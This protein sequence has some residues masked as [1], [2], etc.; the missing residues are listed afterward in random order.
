MA[1][2]IQAS[3]SG[4]ADRQTLKQPLLKQDAEI[5]TMVPPTRPSQ[6]RPDRQKSVKK[7]LLNKTRGRSR[8][9]TREEGRIRATWVYISTCTAVM[10]TAS[11]GFWM[12]Y[13]SPVQ[14]QIVDSLNLTVSEFS[15]FGSLI[16]V[17]AMLGSVISGKIGDWLGR[18][19]AMLVACL[20]IIV[21]SSLIAFAQSRVPLYIG[22]F[23]TG[24]GGGIVSFVVPV[25]IAEI[26]PRHLRGTLGSMQQ[27]AV[28]VGI[29]LAYLGG[30]FLNWRY[31][32]AAGTLP[33]FLCFIGL[34]VI[35]ESPRWLASREK[36]EELEAALQKLR[37][38][39][40]DISP[41]VREM[42]QMVEASKLEP[43]AK[44]TDLFSKRLTRPLLAGV[45]LQFLQQF[46]GINGVMLYASA[47]F[48]SA[49][50]SNA[51]AA[52]LALAILQV[53]MTLAAAGLMDKAGRR[54]LLM[55]SG[56]GMALSCFLVG[57]SFYLRNVLSDNYSSGMDIFIDIL[58]LASLLVYIAAF[59]LGLGP[60]PWV[61]IAE[62]FPAKVKGV[63]GSLA[64]LV[65][66]SSAWMVTL[67]FNI[68]FNWS[69]AGSFW[70]FSLVCVFAVIFVALFVP[71]TKGRTL[72][73][74]EASFR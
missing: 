73:Q 33:C 29:V 53:V 30:L 54:L 59:S 31:L 11:L 19:G 8:H 17:G 55:V 64:T 44:F 71:E 70:I 65:N 63:A 20:P 6:S 66:W 51:N 18:K 37:G 50:I 74:I 60:V 35:P 40:Y 57:F 68:V 38:P 45:G 7:T 26:A 13:T 9:M 48:S 42:E 27:F 16:T 1:P 34:T 69:A 10:G 32:A 56:S 2:P 25:Y 49:G 14:Q 43:S 21:G 67:T 52:S 28:T 46:S 47:I 72:E 61:V 23:L 39:Q 36:K 4:T 22:R 12:G 5:S 41:E 15:L 62:V 24:T 3:T 58:A